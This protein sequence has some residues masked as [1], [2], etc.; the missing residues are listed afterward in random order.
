MKGGGSEMKTLVYW[1]G[2]ILIGFGIWISF[3]ALWI[4]ITLITPWWRL[5]AL[6]GPAILLVGAII[7]IVIGRR[8][9]KDVR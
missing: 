8:M 1:I 7:F 9:M 6:S 4:Y 3:I 2:L 5:G